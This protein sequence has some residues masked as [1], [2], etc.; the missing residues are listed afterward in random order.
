MIYFKSLNGKAVRYRNKL[1]V[2]KVY[3]HEYPEWFKNTILTK[4]F[5]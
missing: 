5:A 4:T 2:K 1:N 3:D